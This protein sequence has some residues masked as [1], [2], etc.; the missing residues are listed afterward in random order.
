M[1]PLTLAPET[2][3]M[4]VLALGAH[5]DDVE[6]GAGGTLLRLAEEMP[7]LRGHVVVL[8]STPERAAEAQTSAKAFLAPAEA[9]CEVHELWD[10]RLPSRWNETKEVLEGLA[11]RVDADV[12]LAPSPHDAHQDHRLLGELVRTSF[13]DH[14]VLHYE[15]PKWDGDLG[16]SA[17]THYVPLT[18][19]QMQRKCA[20]LQESFPSQQGRD[21]FSDETFYALA[22]LRGMEC[23]ARYAEAF[24]VGK[25]VLS[26][27]AA[28]S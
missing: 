13:R 1:L 2:G 25:A 24:N 14:L 18:P 3:A 11:R 21:W 26:W 16:S 27:G 4:T 9:T 12:V 8:T 7:G 15:I 6:I 20:L 22:R 5:P 23:R 28:R 19:S 10:G 17:A